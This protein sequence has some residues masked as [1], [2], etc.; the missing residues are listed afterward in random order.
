MIKIKRVSIN[1]FQSHKNTVLDFSEGLN[2]ITGPSDQGK[3]AVIRAIKWVIYNEPRG[4][5]FIRY[6]ATSARVVLELYNGNKIIRERTKN[7]NRY[8]IVTP[9]EKELNF[10]GFGSEVPEEVVKI[11]GTPKVSLDIGLHS[12]INIAEQLEGPFLLTETGAARAKAIGRFAGLHIIDRAL[13]DCITDL[14]RENQ[15]VERVEAELESTQKK[16]KEYRKLKIVREKIKRAEKLTTKLENRINKVSY[17]EARKSF[18]DVI[19]KNQKSISSLL[20]NFQ[21]IKEYE[22]YISKAQ[23]KLNH[24]KK[25]DRYDNVLYSIEEQI[26]SISSI[27]EKTRQLDKFENII[28]ELHNKLELLKICIKTKQKYDHT[29]KDIENIYKCIE[30]HR[31]QTEE[32]VE[33]FINV[34]TLSG[35][36]PLCKSKISN[37]TLK[38][39][40]NHYKEIK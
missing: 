17:M 6:G 7:K 9:D 14:R 5:D 33:D 39:I 31:K 11:L 40:I 32:L 22:T 3:S 38:N 21:N 10:E 37:N 36:C 20:D 25:L 27:V 26:R 29:I 13:K 19:D 24:L 12:T 35:Q 30:N 2:V 18:L 4:T 15:A 34:L 16:I 8:K 28:K 23:S 1:N